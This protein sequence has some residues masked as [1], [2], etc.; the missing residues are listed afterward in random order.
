MT[1]T[2]TVPIHIRRKRPKLQ[3]GS[4]GLLLPGIITIFVLAI[5]PLFIVARNSFANA[6][7]YGG[8]VGG[9]TLDNY[10]GL[11]DPAYA[12]ML[13]Y[14]LLLA[15][16]NTVICVVLGYL[17]SY[18]IVTRPEGR[19]G[20]LLLLVIVP[21]W[22]DFI[23]RTFAWITLLGSKGPVSGIF[24]LFGNE[25]FTLIPSEF[26]VLIGM[27]YAFLPT[28][29]FPIYASMRSVD[30]SLREAAEDL[31]CGWFGVHRRVWLPLSKPGVLGAVL[32]TFVPTMGAFFIPILL[33]GGKNPIIGNIIVTLYTEF[34]NQPMGAALSMVLLLLLIVSAALLLLGLREKKAKAPIIEGKA[35][36]G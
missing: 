6:D 10:A 24:G 19:Q 34:R 4:F 29:V 17:T 2:S 11:A 23:V 32:L 33:G 5:V 20:F 21:F 27:V 31:G 30:R 16:V 14:S 3:Y 22:T 7:N 25:G 1:S 28:A 9:F 26:S 8:I 13:G 36:R 12:K 18:F 35:Q 15:F